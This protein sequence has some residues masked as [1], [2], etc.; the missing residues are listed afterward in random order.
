MQGKCTEVVSI[1][2]TN[3]EGPTPW[4]KDKDKQECSKLLNN[5]LKAFPGVEFTSAVIYRSATVSSRTRVS[6]RIAGKRRAAEVSFPPEQKDRPADELIADSIVKLLDKVRNWHASVQVILSVCV[7]HPDRDLMHPG[8]R[9][10]CLRARAR[11][12]RYSTA[13][14][15]S[16][17][18]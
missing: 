4:T 14:G 13:R 8:L 5:L 18:T 17:R 2:T 16:Q 6:V 12:A 7:P 11:Y 3:K 10:V 15:P 1:A 9:V